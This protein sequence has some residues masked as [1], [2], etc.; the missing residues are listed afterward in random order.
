MNTSAPDEFVGTRFEPWGEYRACNISA[1]CFEAPFGSPV[2]ISIATCTNFTEEAEGVNV[3]GS[4]IC[5][6]SIMY[7]RFGPAC[8]EREASRLNIEAAFF[9]LILLVQLFNLFTFCRLLIRGVTAKYLQNNALTW[10]I[11][12]CVM[13]T[14]IMLVYSGSHVAGCLGVNAAG[15]TIVISAALSGM[16][17]CLTLSV[18][19]LSWQE[20]L[21]TA[22]IKGKRKGVRVSHQLAA[23]LGGAAV[24]V[25]NILFLTSSRFALAT[26]TV[27]FYL[28]LLFFVY[29]YVGTNLRKFLQVSSTGSSGLSAKADSKLQKVSNRIKKC[30]HQVM[31]F[32]V[33]F[34]LSV[35]IISMFSTTSKAKG[36]EQPFIA[37]AGLFLMHA[38]PAF[39]TRSIFEC[40]AQP[41]RMRLKKKNAVVSMDMSSENSSV[42]ST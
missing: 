40:C 3:T 36:L 34:I 1:D 13:T 23:G 15:P 38:S 24:G 11:I 21:N 18:C 10:T 14:I 6:C 35:L 32:I 19:I 39:C 41:I 7:G 16:F 4:P 17:V 26:Q 28:I 27:L 31:A 25:L 22:R 9:C 5:V 42:T 20:I 8:E 2:Y 37:S 33:A 30:I 12:S 29:V